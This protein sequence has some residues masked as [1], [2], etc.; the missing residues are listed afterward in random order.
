M[1]ES[2]NMRSIQDSRLGAELDAEECEALCGAMR[3]HAVADGDVLAQEGEHDEMLYLLASGTL[4]VFR[5]EE[6][7]EQHLHSMHAGE[8]AGVTGLLGYSSR[9]T[10]LRARGD[11]VV[12]SLERDAL[13]SLLD[14]HAPVAYKIM[15]SIA[16]MAYDIIAELGGSIEQ[17]TNYVT[18]QH[19]RY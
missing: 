15:R 8:L 5:Q 11:V 18:K 4:D 7:A 1:G 19:G 14:G 13:E 9:N 16:R 2:I 17:L 3:V 10:T 6:H 12:Y